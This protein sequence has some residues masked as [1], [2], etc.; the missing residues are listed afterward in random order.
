MKNRERKKI[1]GI[2]LIEVIVAL[3]ILVTGI[4]SSY[5]LIIRALASY[6]F[7]A[8]RLVAANLIQE[9]IESVRQIRDNNYANW[10]QAYKNHLA[11]SWDKNV[12][13]S[14]VNCNESI[15]FNNKIYQR[16]TTITK[17]QGRK[18]VIIKVNIDYET[19]G[20]NYT[21]SAEDHLFDWADMPI[22]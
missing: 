22:P 7:I 12:N 3:S 21:L 18:E 9:K 6:R 14:Y 11:W 4:L 2:A 19:R 17:T 1:K 20:Q 5:F 13:C 16:K 10:S 8:D 15:N